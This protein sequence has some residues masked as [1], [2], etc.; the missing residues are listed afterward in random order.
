MGQKARFHSHVF[1]YTE[2]PARNMFPAKSRVPRDCSGE[3][4]LQNFDVERG[5]LVLASMS[6][7]PCNVGTSDF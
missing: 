1:L 4:K 6:D 3:G 2:V 7:R 5:V